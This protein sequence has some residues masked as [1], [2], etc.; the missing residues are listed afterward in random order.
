MILLIF[1]RCKESRVEDSNLYV[2][3]VIEEIFVKNFLEGMQQCQLDFCGLTTIF[4]FLR[5]DDV[6]AA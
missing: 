2:D 3:A 6:L 5:M 4:N 1:F